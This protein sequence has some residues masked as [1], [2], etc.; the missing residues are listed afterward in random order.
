MARVTR[1]G[2]I[3]EGHSCHFPPTPAIA[4]SPDVNV[5]GRPVV[6]EGDAYGP[7]DCPTCPA[8]AHSRFLS[9]GS[10]SVFANG[11][12]LGRTDDPISC[13]GKAADGSGNVSAGG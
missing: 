9:A 3:G 13:G 5:N 1:L 4:G 10:A 7:H 11:K 6:R 12:P 2:D 8:P